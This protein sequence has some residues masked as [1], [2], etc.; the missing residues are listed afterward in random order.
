MFT[1]FRSML[2]VLAVLAASGLA[3]AEDAPG[4]EDRQKERMEALETALMGQDF[5][6]ALSV[7][8]KMVADKEVPEDDRFKAVFTQFII[9]ATEKHDG[10]KACPLAKKLSEQKK[11]NAEFLN[12]LS[13][14]ILDT[15][16]LKDRDLDLALVIAKQAAEASKFEDGAILDTLARAHFE[17]GDL[18]RAIEFQTKAVEKV[19]GNDMI[20]D[21]IKAQVKD[22][23]EKYKAKKAEKTEKKKDE[24]KP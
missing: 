5:D 9:L 17:K 3:R 1:K 8:D 11:D 10:A 24:K 22:T 18:D 7:L 15:E 14:T 6:A 13:W 12:E 20:G 19:E 23:L 2:A 4:V 21:D 16:G